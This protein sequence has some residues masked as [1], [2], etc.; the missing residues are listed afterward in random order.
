MQYIYP[1]LFLY[2]YIYIHTYT[3]AYDAVVVRCFSSHACSH[4]LLAWIAR[5]LACILARPYRP[6]RPR[7]AHTWAHWHVDA[8]IYT[9]WPASMRPRIKFKIMHAR[10]AQP[11][12]FGAVCQDHTNLQRIGYGASPAWVWVPI[13]ICIYMYMY[14][15]IHAYAYAYAYAYT[16]IT[17]CVSLSIYIYI[18]VYMCVC[19]YIYIYIYTHIYI[20][21]AP[22]RQTSSSWTIC[23]S[24]CLFAWRLHLRGQHWS[25]MRPIRN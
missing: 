9:Q 7:R 13:N 10:M 11:L 25:I 5:M 2:I 12:R 6:Q 4:E 8:S 21:I 14:I 24:S 1:S 3:H 20:Y 22:S 18:Y 17:I 23:S 15:C 19:T 16:H